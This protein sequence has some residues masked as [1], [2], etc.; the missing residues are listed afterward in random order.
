M[1]NYEKI[2]NMSIEEMAVAI[3]NGAPFDPCDYCK[4]YADYYC[5]GDRCRNL[6]DNEIVQ[7]WLE[8]EV[9]K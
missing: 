8:S 3:A 7:N 9:E 5:H 4:K 2:Q 6:E 1:T